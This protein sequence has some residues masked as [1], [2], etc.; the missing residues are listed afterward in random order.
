MLVTEIVQRKKKESEANTLHTPNGSK[1]NDDSGTKT[2]RS[3]QQL[4]QV[5]GHT[6]SK[7]LFSTKTVIAQ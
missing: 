3:Q 2:T 5:A 6:S 7:G 1:K 4:F